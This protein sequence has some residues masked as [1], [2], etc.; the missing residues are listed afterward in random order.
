[1]FMRSPPTEVPYPPPAD[2]KARRRKSRPSGRGDGGGRDWV[3]KEV[4][5]WFG[6]DDGDDEEDREADTGREPSRG[7]RS[8]RRRSSEQSSWSF[9]G[10]VESFL[11]L[12]RMDMDARAV[13]YD[14]KMGIERGRSRDGR[15]RRKQSRI[16]PMP[17]TAGPSRRRERRKGYA[18]RY[19]DDDGT[20][21][22]AEVDALPVDDEDDALTGSTEAGTTNG[23][24][25]ASSE[26]EI[27]WEERALAVERVPPAGIPA[28]GPSGDLGIDARTKAILDALED[29]Q[30]AK[31]VVNERK[32]AVEKAKEDVAILRIDAE[33]EKK[34]LRSTVREARMLQESIRQLDFEVQESS[35]ALRY[36]QSRLEI[37]QSE[38]AA[39]ERRHW[40]VLS[41]YNPAQVEEAVQDAIRE[42]EK[43]EPAARLHRDKPDKDNDPLGSSTILSRDADEEQVKV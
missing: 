39:L 5:S 34:R 31:E 19:E 41:F 9:L 8:D 11:G 21:P 18:Y 24:T 17:S 43:N 7:R 22:I 10:A 27:P 40:A 37:S 35:R 26:T 6:P 42:F 4:S 38:L 13:E 25:R 32:A 12:D 28:W 3:S 14:R 33:L 29:I 2:S 23:P 30:L 36:A 15:Q 20:P 16:D 1:M